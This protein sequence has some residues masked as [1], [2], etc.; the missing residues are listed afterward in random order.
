MLLRPTSKYENRSRTTTT[1]VYVVTFFT[2]E[3]DLLDF[4]IE[5]VLEIPSRWDMALQSI[6]ENMQ[7]RK[8]K[9]KIENKK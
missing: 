6:R 3:E 1:I 4:C 5:V 7:I 8:N 2:L 9:L